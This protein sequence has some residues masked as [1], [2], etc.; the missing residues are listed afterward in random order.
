MLIG[1]QLGV[2]ATLMLHFMGPYDELLARTAAHRQQVVNASDRLVL[3]P[4]E[5]GGEQTTGVSERT[6][7]TMAAGLP[8]PPRVLPDSGK[9]QASGV[10]LKKAIESRVATA[11]KTQPSETAGTSSCGLLRTNR[12][13]GSYHAAQ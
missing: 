9:Q 12:S 5:V 1:F 10:L 2:C 8:S 6:T 7:A 4:D 3:L 11:V 13:P